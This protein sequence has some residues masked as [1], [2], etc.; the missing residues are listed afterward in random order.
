MPR[1]VSCFRGEAVSDQRLFGQF[2]G[3]G[4][5]RRRRRRRKVVADLL[6]RVVIARVR[7]RVFQSGE[8]LLV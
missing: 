3:N 7:Y 1:E 2:M 8:A 4:S 6:E 5:R